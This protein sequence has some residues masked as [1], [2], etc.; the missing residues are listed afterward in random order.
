MTGTIHTF[1]IRRSLF[2]AVFLLCGLS[3]GA[4]QAALNTSDTLY[5]DVFRS[6]VLEYHPLA[7]QADLN[8]DQAAALLLRAK[9]GFDPKLYA[10]HSAKHF[11][12]K[13]YFRYSEAGLKWPGWLGLELKGGY[14]YTSGAYLNPESNLPSDGQA[15]FGL[16]WSIG[17]GLFTDDRRTALQLARIGVRQGEAARAAALNDLLY[18]AAKT[19]WAWVAVS[20]QLSIYEA[21]YRQAAIRHEGIRESYRQGDKPAVDTL[22]SFIQMQ[23]RALDLN[24]AGNEARNAALDL[25]NFLWDKDMNPADPGQLKKAPDITAFPFF[26]PVTEDGG[27][28]AARARTQHPELLM[29]ENKIKS[30][31]AERR[32]KAEKRKPVLDLSYTLLGSGWQFFPTPGIDG[33][34]V[35]ANDIKWGIQFSYPILNRKVRGDLQ[36]TEVKMV[37]TDYER[38]LKQ[39]SIENKI[40]A[41]AN[42]LS[43]LSS[44]VALYRGITDDYGRL[45]EAENEKFRF[46]ES[47]VFLINTREQRWLDA[48]IKYLKLLAEYRKTE[49]ALQW[50]AGML[51]N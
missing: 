7:R 49:A 9:G 2:F 46:G 26:A 6:Q 33:A 40:L 31:E 38:R 51:A 10:D 23:N 34:A 50:A 41:A 15:S 44:Q 4:A 13:N 20:N 25:C 39:Q 28:L 8:L 32:L 3:K 1:T 42:D 30:L 14:Q 36:V 18:E 37:Q 35:L 16:N 27:T 5:W 22:E 21:A 47:S 11:A 19:Y 43:N 45:L 12:D 29:Y 48:R 17:Q 24:F